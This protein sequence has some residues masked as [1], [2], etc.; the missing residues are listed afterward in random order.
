LRRETEATVHF[1]GGV[2]LDP[3]N[4]VL[5]KSLQTAYNN[6]GLSPNPVISNGSGYS[7]NPELPMVRQQLNEAA[8]MLVQ[9]FEDAKRFEPSRQA[10]EQFIKR[11]AVPREAFSNTLQ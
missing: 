4:E 1:L 8:V 9:R 10:R 2:L 3:A 7:L 11:Y 6:Q 5:W